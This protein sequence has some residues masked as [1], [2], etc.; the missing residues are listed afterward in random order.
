MKLIK[1]NPKGELLMMLVQ[2]HQLLQ[3]SLAG[4]EVITAPKKCAFLKLE[5][6]KQNVHT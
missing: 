4:T 6:L 3:S 2:M 5:I 1:Q